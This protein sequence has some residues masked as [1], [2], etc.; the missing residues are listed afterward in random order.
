[1]TIRIPLFR[2]PKA[3]VNRARSSA[4]L[5]INVSIRRTHLPL[6]LQQ[7]NATNLTPAFDPVVGVVAT[8]QRLQIFDQIAFLLL[9]EAQTKVGVVVVHHVA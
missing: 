2:N 6:Q 9:G 3:F 5:V 4:R 7:G 1:M 8:S